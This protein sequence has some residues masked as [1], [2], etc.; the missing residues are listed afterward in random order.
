MAVCNTDASN[1][2]LLTVSV[3]PREETKSAVSN[4]HVIWRQQVAANST[5]TLQ[6]DNYSIT[7]DPLQK[8]LVVADRT[9]TFYL[10]QEA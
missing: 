4:F 7:L 10:V 5:S 9:V 1:A 2:A 8:L 6:F 3:Q